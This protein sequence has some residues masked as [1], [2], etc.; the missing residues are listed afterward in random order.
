[1]YLAESFG[2]VFLE[3]ARQ[4]KY[5]SEILTFKEK[6]FRLRADRPTLEKQLEDLIR[7]DKSILGLLKSVANA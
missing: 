3:N 4:F 2:F 6:N 1:L 7:E 5:I